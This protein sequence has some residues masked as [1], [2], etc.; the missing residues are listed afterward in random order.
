MIKVRY[1]LQEGQHYKHWQFKDTK[2]KEVWYIH[3][4]EQ[5]ITLHNCVLHNNR[6]V[7]DKIFTGSNKDVCAW[8]K[9]KG[10]VYNF[11]KEIPSWSTHL[12]YDPRKLPYWHTWSGRNIDGYAFDIL[13][14]TPK[15]V[16]Y[17]E[18]REGILNPLKVTT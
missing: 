2:T 16:Y 10:M 18:C 4:S 1:H 14:L 3:P 11:D 17:N 8:V 6:N 5:T 12:I 7:A 15:G 9:C 13:H